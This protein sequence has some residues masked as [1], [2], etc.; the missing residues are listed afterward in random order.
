MVSYH[1]VN[2]DGTP[3]AITADGFPEEWV[4][5][6]IEKNL[7]SVDPIPE[8][9]ARLSRPFFW[10]DISTLVT[11]TTKHESYLTSMERARL[12][13]GLAFYVFGP[14]LQNAYVGLGFGVD[15]IDLDRD[16]VFSFQCIAQAGHLQFCTLNENFENHEP[17]TP[18]E[19]EVLE[20]VARGKS[21]SVI[22]EIVGISVHTVDAHIRGI[23]RKL[24]VNDRTSAA[25][26]GLG[27]GLV[28]LDS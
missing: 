3:L 10:H 6:Y 21:N 2:S 19:R 1:A 5:E 27:R 24:E 26:R 9:A 14:A 15:R 13:D 28:R 4:C 7:V 17:L 11:Q 8:L 12:G 16:T 20:W 22:A 18:R 23:Y 25:I